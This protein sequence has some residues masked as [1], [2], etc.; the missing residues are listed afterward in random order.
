M[1]LRP[2]GLLG[3]LPV[4]TSSAPLFCLPK[5]TDPSLL[6]PS[7]SSLLLCRGFPSF[8]ERE[9]G[10]KPAFIIPAFPPS[11][12]CA[13]EPPWKESSL[14]ALPHPSTLLQGA[15][16]ETSSLPIPHRICSRASCL[17]VWGRSPGPERNKPPPASSPDLATPKLQ[18]FTVHGLLGI[19]QRSP[20]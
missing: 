9:A 1:V 5:H 7:P 19:V 8:L 16:E 2:G 3:A 18:S 13:K 4:H 12:P 15:E 14:S 11:G 6:H 17:A 20:D 10:R